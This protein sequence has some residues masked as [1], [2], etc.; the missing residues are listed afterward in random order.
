FTGRIPG[1]FSNTLRLDRL[2]RKAAYA[3]IM[4]P[5]ERYAELTDAAVSVEAALAERVLDEVGAGQIEPALGGLGAV[6]GADD[7]ARIEAPYLQLVMQRIWD[8]ELAA[9]SS[10][11]RAETLERLGG[12]QHIVEEHLA[13]AM[14]EL[15]PDQKDI[16]ARLF[17]HLVTPSGTKIA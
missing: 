7:G 2:D 3:A 9:R 17:N 8:E 12:A 15:M 6:E 16:A 5:V 1:V 10:V 11:L 13:G 14:A 4:R